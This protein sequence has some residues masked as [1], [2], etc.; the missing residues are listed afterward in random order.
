MRF[1]EIFNKKKFTLISVFLFLYV[2]FNLLEG[3]RG[4]IS[5]FEKQKIKK[6]LIQEKK[7][8]T[9]QLVFFE[10]KID[11]LTSKID[12]DYLEILYRIKF[13]VGKLNEK[14]YVNKN[15]TETSRKN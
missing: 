5:Y 14:I 2:A 1:I 4:V 8:F 9:T 10:K 7:L 3:E 13:M 11:L 15:E 12:L 6:Q